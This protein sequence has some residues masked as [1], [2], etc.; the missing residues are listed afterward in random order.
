MKLVVS[1]KELD[2]V[3]SYMRDIKTMVDDKNTI[4]NIPKKAS[5]N[6]KWGKIEL[7]DTECTIELNEKCF[8]AYMA[9]CSSMW[10]FLA[11][12]ITIIKGFQG[13]VQKLASQFTENWV[14]TT[15]MSLIKLEPIDIKTVEDFSMLRVP[16]TVQ[17]NYKIFTPLSNIFAYFIG[18]DSNGFI[19]DIIIKK[20]SSEKFLVMIFHN[21]AF[22]YFY[23]L[24]EV[25]DSDYN[26][27][28]TNI[29]EEINNCAIVIHGTPVIAVEW[30]P[31]I[32]KK[33]KNSKSDV[34]TTNSI[35]PDNA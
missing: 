30:R 35:N 17:N 24:H 28:T 5:Y 13:F 26:Y 12:L 8:I 31:I 19:F 32:V 33:Q 2:S 1:R 18:T 20:I 23:E 11:P 15:T 3:E 25:L 14:T 16:M 7:T 9:L 4:D 6:D 29:M 27:K 10:Y 34:S 21:G 22:I